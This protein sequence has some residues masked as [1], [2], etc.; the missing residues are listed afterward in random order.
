MSIVLRGQQGIEAGLYQSG[1]NGGRLTCTTVLCIIVVIDIHTAELGFQP[2]R[3]VLFI[4]GD[5]SFSHW[6]LL[7]FHVL[8]LLR[9]LLGIR[10]NS[11]I[12]L[13]PKVVIRLLIF[14]FIL[15]LFRRLYKFA[16]PWPLQYATIPSPYR[17]WLVGLCVS[18]CADMLFEI[19]FK[20]QS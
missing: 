20:G 1:G 16:I 14:A 9:C 19:H 17:T 4:G 15:R 6:L 2:S 10:A 8:T 12:I 5:E 7:L 11:C 13:V 3:N 18:M